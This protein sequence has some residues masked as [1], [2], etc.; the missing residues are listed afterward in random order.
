MGFLAG[1]AARQKEIPAAL[2]GLVAAERAF[3]KLSVEKGVREAF[4][5]YFADDGVNFQPH[6]TKTIESYRSRPAPKS[7]PPTRLNWAPIYGDV[8]QAGDLGYS[9]GP[10]TIEDQSEQKR[11]TGH[12]MFFSIWR[13][14]RDGDWRVVVDLGIGLKTPFAP[15]DAPYRPAP[16]WKIPSPKLAIAQAGNQPFETER[17]FHQLAVAHG[18]A[19]AWRQFLS[20][21]AWI[22]RPDLSPIVGP[23]A[24]SQW[25]GRQNETLVGK[26]IKTDISRSGDLGYCYGSYELKGSENKTAEK[27]YYVRVWK[28]DAKGNWKIVFDVCNRLP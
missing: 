10:Y 14:Q 18:A 17:E 19:Q 13:R 26:T 20:A 1:A 5:T 28:L 21:D 9:T 22:Y 4:M 24:V 11:P 6:P 7:L 16:K 23:E 25:A 15:L 12:G 3:A 8:S 27:G 2:S